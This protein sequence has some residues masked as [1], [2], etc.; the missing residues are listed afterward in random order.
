MP[1][2]R[3]RSVE[4][5]GGQR[6]PLEDRV[7]GSAGAK[8]QVSGLVVAAMTIITLL[9]LT[10]LFEKLPE[11]TLAAVVIVG[12]LELVDIGALV[13]L[14]GVYTGRVQPRTTLRPGPT[15]SR[16]LRRCWA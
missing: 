10:G 4:R 6:E 9:F 15:S 8:S 1:P 3:G 12:R 5:H 16:R 11:A 14:Y 7:N 13:R 2:T